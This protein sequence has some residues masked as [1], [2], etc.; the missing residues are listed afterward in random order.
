M[1]FLRKYMISFL[2]FILLF[3][4]ISYGFRSIQESTSIHELESLEK[5]LYRGMMECYA[6]EG[7]YPS[8]IDYLVD[9]YHI[10]YNQE[11]YDIQYEVI[12][13]NIIPNI[14]IIEKD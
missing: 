13:S 4:V 2:S 1:K 11:K 7:R 5:A 9:N 12:A 3:G 10:I 8:H 6:L 14:T